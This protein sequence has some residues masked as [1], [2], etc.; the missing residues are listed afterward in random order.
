LR[1]PF[2]EGIFTPYF[3]VTL[4]LIHNRLKNVNAVTDTR[5]VREWDVA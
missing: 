1:H 4:F 3:D 2:D 5:N